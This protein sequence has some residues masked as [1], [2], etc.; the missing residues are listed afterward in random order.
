MRASLV[1]QLDQSEA[2]AGAALGARWAARAQ[3]LGRASVRKIGENR[4]GNRDVEF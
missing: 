1:R 4:G 3:K 2:V